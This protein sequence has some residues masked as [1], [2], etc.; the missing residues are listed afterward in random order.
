MRLLAEQQTAQRCHFQS[1]LHRSIGLPRARLRQA[2][3]RASCRSV[4]PRT[5]RQLQ[6]FAPA[7]RCPLSAPFERVASLAIR[8]LGLDRPHVAACEQC[9]TS[10]AAVLSCFWCGGFTVAHAGTCRKHEASETRALLALQVPERVHD[11]LI[12]LRDTTR[13]YAVQE[14]TKRSCSTLTG[15]FFHL[16]LTVRADLAVRH[17]R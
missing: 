12:M 3:V 7:C 4:L 10:K 9:Q 8:S 17:G 11:A 13:C 5:H 14:N 15:N 1:R 6:R 2:G 16:G